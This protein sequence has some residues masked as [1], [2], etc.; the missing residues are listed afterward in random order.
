MQA[1]YGFK[2]GSGD[3]FLILDSDKCNGCGKCVTACP[4]CILE[5]GEDENDPFRDEPVARVKSSERNKLRY[6]CAP[7]HPGYGEKS[8]PCINACA[9]EAIS[10]AE[11]WK[12]VYGK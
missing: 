8:P 5:V 1:F 7:C 12:K 4:S 3:W 10:H 2:D 6:D 9:P 11:T